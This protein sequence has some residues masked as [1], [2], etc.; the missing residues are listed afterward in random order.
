MT[1]VAVFA[2]AIAAGVASGLESERLPATEQFRAAI[3][4]ID[5]NGQGALQSGHVY[6]SQAVP[7]FP[8]KPDGSLESS[9]ES[10]LTQNRGWQALHVTTGTRT[11]VCSGFMKD[12]SST[13]QC[14]AK[15]DKKRGISVPFPQGVEQKVQQELLKV[16]EIWK[17]TESMTFKEDG[18]PGKEGQFFSVDGDFPDGGQPANVGKGGVKFGIPGVKFDRK[19]DW[20]AALEKVNE[21]ALV[22]IDCGTGASRGS[23]ECLPGRP[24][25]YSVVEAG[26][27]FEDASK[28]AGVDTDKPVVPADAAKDA[29]K[30]DGG[31]GNDV[32]TADAGEQAARPMEVVPT[33]AVKDAQK[34]DDAHWP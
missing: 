3:Q 30:A 33:D 5:E 6:L 1:R 19:A 18:T 16:K 4:K 21:W 25:Q 10:A 20:R 7:V 22:V 31:R 9:I 32:V 8:T 15:F 23:S 12:C 28:E 29:D 11:C 14:G 27:K 24:V 17:G 34:A 2:V 26:F 13:E